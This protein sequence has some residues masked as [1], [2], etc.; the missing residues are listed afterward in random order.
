MVSPVALTSWCSWLLSPPITQVRET[1]HNAAQTV[2][3]QPESTPLSVLAVL[4]MCWYLNLGDFAAI[5]VY[6][7]HMGSTVVER[8]VRS[9][10]QPHHRS[11][12]LL[13][14][15]SS[16]Y[17]CGVLCAVAGPTMYPP[18]TPDV[19]SSSVKSFTPIMIDS[20]LIDS[21]LRVL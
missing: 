1:R 15:S 12:P 7:H 10:W 14:C 4:L 11:A 17:F 18:R 21:Y 20:Y 3:T 19:C 2:A 8:I 6:S 9:S 13:V 16:Y 5:M